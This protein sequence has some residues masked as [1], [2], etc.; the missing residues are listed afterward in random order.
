MT[1]EEVFK[2]YGSEK[3]VVEEAL[4]RFLTDY[5]EKLGNRASSMPINPVRA[6]KEFMAEET[7]C[8]VEFAE[9]SKIDTLEKN[10]VY[11]I[12]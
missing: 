11:Y 1:N 7:L 5:W 4:V 2:E 8:S 9:K 3:W 12:E 10:E 6:A